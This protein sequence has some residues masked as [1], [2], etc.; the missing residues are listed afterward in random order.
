MNSKTILLVEDNPDDEEL[1]LRSLR[2]ANVASDIQITRDG[3][4][5]VNYL[6]C[7]GDYAGRDPAQ[8]PSLVVLDLKLPKMDGFDVLKRMRED[9]RTRLIPVVVLSSSSE[10]EDILRSYE[11]GAN[12]YVR[13]P[14]DFA[15]FAEAVNNLS[16]YWLVH[17]EEPPRP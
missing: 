6:Y 12:S 3:S 15:A 14:V 17:N 7:E 16:C 4:E 13:K 5:A 2:K 1:T 9:E 8:V 10:E 11:S